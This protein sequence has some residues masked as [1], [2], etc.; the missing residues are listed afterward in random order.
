[1]RKRLVLTL[2]SL[3]KETVR[4]NCHNTDFIPIR[5][6]DRLDYMMSICGEIY[7][8]TYDTVIVEK[9]IFKYVTPKFEDRFFQSKPYKYLVI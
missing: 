9:D 7:E 2:A 8:T 4:K 1:M 3:S 6:I 5:H